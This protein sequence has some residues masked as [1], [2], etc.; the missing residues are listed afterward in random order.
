[1][2]QPTII[3]PVFNCFAMTRQCLDILVGTVANEIVVV[4]D[5]S[6]DETH[7][8]LRSYGNRI[9]VVTHPENLGFAISCNDGASAASGDSFVFLNNDTLPRPGWL[10]ALLHHARQHPQAAIIGGKLLYPDE[11][12]Q[13]AG[14]VICQDRYPR[15]I[16]T[17][18]PRNHPA[19]SGSRPFQIV[20]AACMLVRREAFEE[21]G[22]FD[23]LFRNGFEDVDLCLR[24]NQT[25][26]EVHY[27]GECEVV[28]LE[29][30]SPG[31]FANDAKNVSL[32]RERWFDTIEPD[33][34]RYYLADGLIKVSHEGRYPIHLEVSPLLATIT[35]DGRL[36]ETEKLLRT[37]NR[38]VADY[39]K[40]NTRL[41]MEIAGGTATSQELEYH[42][43]RTRIQKKIR[44]TIPVGSTVVF[45]S[46]GD[47]ALVDL[48]GYQGW[49]FPMDKNGAYA[50]FH[51]S[52]SQAAISHLDE[53]INRGAE[54]L[55]IPST[56][57]WWLKHYTEFSRQLS[58]RF[59]L[60]VDVQ[61]TCQI[62]G[63]SPQ[64]DRTEGSPS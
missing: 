13:H 38:Q 52:D 22:G 54:Y 32:Y 14:V 30:V 6:T 58:S 2:N 41:R 10:H 62:Y 15:H 55:V 56:S 40:E 59:S 1:M 33:E 23:P 12:V 25:A 50:G 5:G 19:V 27:C 26:G 3:I 17:G 7:S 29:S 16:Y 42:G 51:P 24:V 43:L 28:H 34:W 36:D 47:Q 4:D 31:R 49:H 9:K 18:F 44:E 45:I 61:Q 20:T 64:P 63:L 8:S 57:L 53:L 60:A 46:K 21:V 11:T 48:E 35:R 39:L 37:R